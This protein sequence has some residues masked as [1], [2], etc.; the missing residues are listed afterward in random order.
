MWPIDRPGA[1][2]RG[3][4]AAAG[5]RGRVFGDSHLPPSLSGESIQQP[6]QHT[7]LARASAHVQVSIA[8]LYGRE[9]REGGDDAGRDPS[10]PPA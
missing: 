5:V 9:L 7:V 3:Y 1:G 4:D 10:G 8:V 2:D 6:R